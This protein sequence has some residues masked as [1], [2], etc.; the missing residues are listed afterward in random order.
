MPQV[1]PLPVRS[2]SRRCDPSSLSF[3]T[4]ADLPDVAGIIGQERA[5]EAVRFAIGIRRYGYNL[6]AL[7]TSGMGKHGFVRAFLERQ[8]A[9]ESAPPDWCY[10]HNFA[11][12]RRPRALRLPAGRGPQLA[13]DMRALVDELRAAIPAVFESEDYRTRRKLVEAQFGEQSERAF[14]AIEERARER[15]VAIIKTPAGVG[16]APLREGEVIPPEKFQKLPGREQE[17]L[18]AEMAAVQQELQ[19]AAGTLP[20]EARRQRD[21]LRRLDR[22]VTASAASHLIDEVRARWADVPVVLEHLGEVQKDVVD[23]AEDFLPPP[24]GANAV[25]ALLGGRGGDRKPARRY[26]VNVLV[27][28]PSASGAPVVYEDH[29]THANLVGRVEHVAEMGNLVTDFTLVQGGAL[30]RANGGYLIVDAR[31]LLLQPLAWDELKRALRSKLVRIESLGQA[32]SLTATAS[33]EPEPIPLEVKVVLLG[34]RHLY[35][36]LS[37]LDPEFPELFKVA[38]DFE[39]EIERTAEGELLYARL[40]GTFARREGLRPLDRGAVARAI[41]QASR[42][43]ADAERLQV[44]AETVADL[45]READHLAGEAGADVV[46]VEHVQAALDAQVRRASRVRERIQEDIRRGT[47]LI[48]SRGDAVGQ[49]NGLVVLQLGGYTFGRPSRITAR[50]R[51]GSGNVVDIEKEVALGGPIHSKGVLILTGFLGQRFASERPLSLGAS[52][53]FEQSYSGV[54]GDSASCAELVALLSALGELPVKQGRAITGSVNQHGQV[55]PIG[56]V[57]EKIEGFFDV[58]RAGGLTGDQGVLVPASNVK[59]LM[60]RSDVVEAA[61]KGLFHVWPVEAVDEAVELLT[62]V[63]AGEKGADGR[64]P[65]GTVN[66]RVDDRLAAFAERAR[67]FG[68]GTPTDGPRA[69]E[70]AKAPESPPPGPPPPAPPAPPPDPRPGD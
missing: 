6:Y 39:E 44:H 30:H 34:E 57:N 60:L 16:M 15:G 9:G 41:E 64:Y 2:L 26:Q 31:R 35:Y 43:A 5:E 7:G 51:L 62:G 47:I 23:N 69:A 63:P 3:A 18:K 50:V 14:A 24:E 42:R 11:D 53:V 37:H 65:E 46:A 70:A 66:R 32:L 40:L 22:L 13:E 59:H 1:P 61:E 67:N 38:A 55:Q 52:L 29:P 21:E 58:C 54:E 68:R 20:R 48:D 33:L 17:R 28:Q 36:L 45:L 12:P 25:K 10:V 4:T 19:D 27:S 8:A 49:V 56:G